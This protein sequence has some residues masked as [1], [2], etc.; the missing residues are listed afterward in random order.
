MDLIIRKE[1][2]KDIPDVY[3]VIT[4]SFK[5]QEFSNQEEVN[6]VKNLRR[7]DDFIPNLSIVAEVSGKIVAY[8]LFSKLK[9]E[10]NDGNMDNILTL[11]PVCVSPHM[12]NKGIGSKLI[13]EGHNIAKNMGFKG[14]LV[15]G[16]KNYYPKFGY[17]S[18]V[19]YNISLNM[20]I[21]TDV[22]MLYE[23]EK[24]YFNKNSGK[25]L[26]SDSFLP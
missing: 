18:I 25:I 26:F 1:T 24:D 4:E 6:L 19:N 23:I 3:K 9:F 21:P 7:T 17:S 2:K 13:R 8:I 14:I 12:Q 10:R 20:D 22:A 11:A 5:S 15:V 16:H